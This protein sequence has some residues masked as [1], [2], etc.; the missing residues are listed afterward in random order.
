MIKPSADQLRIFDIS[1]IDLLEEYK[2][3]PAIATDWHKAVYLSFDPLAFKELGEAQEIE[4]RFISYLFTSGLSL[5]SVESLL[6]NLEKPYR[7]DLRSVYFDFLKNDWDYKPEI[8]EVEEQIEELIGNEDD[9]VLL[10]IK[11]RIEEYLD[12]LEENEE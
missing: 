9:D 2:I 3:T 12:E 1:V 10:E 8:P 7:Y 11:D 5:K 4:F 6:K